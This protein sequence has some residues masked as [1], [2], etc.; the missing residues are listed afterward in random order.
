M[1]PE[2]SS[3]FLRT[4]IYREDDSYAPL[5]TFDVVIRTRSNAEP[6]LTWPASKGK[7]SAFF[8]QGVMVEVG[9]R[10]VES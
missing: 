5:G 6:T 9:G 4:Y 2:V 10:D 8:P 1:L 3:R 7:E